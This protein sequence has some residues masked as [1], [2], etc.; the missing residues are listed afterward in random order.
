MVR[1][2]MY[3]LWMDTFRAETLRWKRLVNIIVENY[4]YYY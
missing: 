1:E 3:G 2:E 4:Y